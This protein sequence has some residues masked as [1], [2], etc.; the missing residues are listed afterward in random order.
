MPSLTDEDS[1]LLNFG[2][3]RVFMAYC[4]VCGKKLLKE[5]VKFCPKC[6]SAVGSARAESQSQAPAAGAKASA[7]WKAMGI[8]FSVILAAFLVYAIT[9]YIG[10]DSGSATDCAKQAKPGAVTCGYCDSGTHAGQCRYCP[11]GTTCSGEICGEMTCK[12]G[13]QPGVTTTPG[14]TNPGGNSGVGAY[15]GDPPLS[16]FTGCPPQGLAGVDLQCSQF[17]GNY[18]FCSIQSCTCYYSDH[19]GSTARAYYHT[20]DGLFFP[21]S[22][23]SSA[24]SCVAA[25]EAA[26]EHCA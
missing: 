22:G 7:F 26:A 24:I 3:V 6:G 20:S 21:C 11:S 5:D 19:T 25:A 13:S 18:E 17:T 16:S 14:T 23:A 15:P 4:M 8:I 1:G 12:G 9:G 2:S 10:S